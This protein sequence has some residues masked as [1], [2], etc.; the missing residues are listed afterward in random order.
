MVLCN[1][2]IFTHIY[3]IYLLTTNQLDIESKSNDGNA[4]SH[5]LRVQ[6]TQAL[7]EVLSVFCNLL[8]AIE[9]KIAN[10]DTFTSAFVFTRKKNKRINEE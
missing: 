4:T 3:F 8:Y 2:N 7:C 6:Y 9:I 10:Q 1:I 5:F